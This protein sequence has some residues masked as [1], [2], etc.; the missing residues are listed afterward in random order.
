MPWEETNGMKSRTKFI[1]EWERRWLAQEGQLDV[2]ELCRI[3]GVSRQTGYVWIRRYQESGRD[4]RVMEE[5]S[6]KPHAS[7]HAISLE[8]QD[9]IVAARKARPRWG[10]RKLRAWLAQRKPAVPLP[11]ISTMSNILRDRG[12]VAPKRRR[13]KQ[14]FAVKQPF[15]ACDRPNA[16]WC[17]DFKGWFRTKDGEKCYPLTLT[18]AYSRYL[19]R[20]EGLTDPDGDAV[21]SIMDSAFRE[22]GIPAAIRSDNG[23]P[24]ASTGPGGLTKLSVWWLRLGIRLERITP[25]KPQEN[26]RHERMHRTLKLE[27]PIAKSLRPQQR[28]FDVFRRRYNEE[29][30]HEA[31]GDA[32]PHTVYEPSKRRYPTPILPPVTS[33][34]DHDQRLDKHGCFRWGRRKVFVSTALIGENVSLCPSVQNKWAVHFGPL[35]LGN[36]DEERLERGLIIARPKRRRGE[37]TELEYTHL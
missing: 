25:G 8:V 22:F 12:L 18:D 10:P 13:R 17:I 11:S 15:S 1:L 2:A 26:G 16:V 14:T 31:L 7:P 37:V 29:R 30:P 5:R 28:E 35:F 23:P 20:C 4:V 3:H 6:R 24:F 34:F 19:L 36:I 9:F 21:E 27:V 32:T 33:G